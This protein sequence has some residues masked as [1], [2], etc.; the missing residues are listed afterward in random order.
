M[1]TITAAGLTDQGKIRKNNEDHYYVDAEQGLFIVSD[2]MGGHAAGELASKVVVEVLPRILPPRLENI[3]DLS[4]P[5]ATETTLDVL[6][7]LSRYV[8]N[9]SSKSAGISGM[10]ATVVLCLIRNNHTLIGHMGDSRAYLLRGEQLKQLTTDHSVVQ[11]LIDTGRITPE[12][13][14]RHPA[15]SRITC[16]VGMQGEALPEARVIELVPDDRL[17]LCTDGLTGMLPPQTITELLHTH[18]D[19]EHACQ[20]LIDA[21]NKAGGKDNITVIVINCS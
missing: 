1:S 20:A 11:L 16:Y 3:Q 14:V 6:S 2:G 7:K 10:G 5:R 4:D 21:A 13:A 18:P 8:R 12:Q 19:P 15:R 17:L 9:E